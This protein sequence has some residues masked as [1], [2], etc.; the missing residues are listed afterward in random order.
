MA[1]DREGV[2][3]VQ[4]ELKGEL[5]RAKKGYKEKIEGKL[6]DNS[7][8]EVW[9]GLK[10][11]TGQKQAGVEPNTESHNTA[12]R[13]AKIADVFPCLA[14]EDLPI[15][16]GLCRSQCG[17]SDPPTASP[18]SAGDP[19][20]LLKDCGLADINVD[21]CEVSES[22]RRKLAE[23][24]LSYQDVFSRHKRDCGEAKEFVHRIRLSDDRPFRLPYRRVPPGHYQQLREVLSDME[25]KG[26][27][28]KSLSEYASPLVM[29]WKKNG[30]LR[31]CTDFRWLNAKTIKDAHPLPHQADCLAA[32]GGNALFS[33][34]DLTSG[35]YNVPLHESDRKFTAFTTPMGLYEYNRLPQGLC[36]SPASF[37]RMMLSIFGDLNF[38]SLLCY[39]DDLLVFAPSEEEA[40]RRLE[41]VFSRL[42]ANNL[43]LSQKKYFDR[44]FIL[45]TDASLDGLGAVLSQVPAGEDKA[46]PIAFASKSLSR[47]QAKYPAHRLEFLALKWAVCDKFSHWLKGH[48][49]TVW[50]D[51][52]P[53]TYIMTKPKLDACEQRWVSKLSPYS[54]EIKHVPG[55]LNVV[56]DALSRTPFVKPLGR[57]L[58]SEQDCW[59]RCAVST[60]VVCR[61][62]SM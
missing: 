61:M 1:K 57:R 32:L 37:M 18:R 60:T 59:N 15:T 20:Q 55:Q 6:E 28:S 51:N 19:V 44:P 12:P 42:R 31:I 53:L 38:S 40:L 36:N 43:K 49:F 46:R 30:D 10:R 9:D 16:Q 50:T 23:L 33:T 26:I 52:N 35:F 48:K 4:K 54:F 56:A 11:I 39:L 41:V 58:L 29:V 25:M 27:I 13:N 2:K 7:T 5:R 45:S 21:G 22:C 62:H 17:L 47:S 34:M 8:R 24:V 3:S 14:V